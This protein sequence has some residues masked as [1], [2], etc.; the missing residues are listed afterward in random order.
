MEDSDPLITMGFHQTPVLLPKEGGIWMQGSHRTT[1]HPSWLGQSQDQ[2]PRLLATRPCHMSA[3]MILTYA[4]ISEIG[5][6]M[7]PLT[8]GKID[9]TQELSWQWDY[10]W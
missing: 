9:H 8:P 4:S 7:S 2:H 6:S 10:Y 5:K 1:A 3:A